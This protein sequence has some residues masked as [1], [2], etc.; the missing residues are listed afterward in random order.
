M[1]LKYINTEGVEVILGAV[2][3]FFITE[4]EGFG[5]VENTLTT[6]KQYALDGEILVSQQ[7]T[8]RELK[9]TGEI[10]ANDIVEM[11]D[12][13]TKLV[14]A[15]NPQLAGTL[16]YSNADKSY[17]IDVVVE[18][19][20]SLDSSAQNLSQEFSIQLKALDPYWIDSTEYNK[21]I[22]LSEVK[23]AFIFPVAV[24]S[25]YVFAHIMTGNITKIS[26]T[27]DVAVGGIF[28]LTMTADVENITI[29]D[30]VTQETF[31]FPH[32][33]D[34]GTILQVNTI[35]GEKQ[36]TKTIDGVTTNA[37]SERGLGSSFLQM[38]KGDNFIQVTAESGTLNILTD[39]KFTPLVMG[40]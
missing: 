13:R 37:I 21:L 36:V 8:T 27:G 5:A 12:L 6:Q 28:T 16:Y 14:S 30:V 24:T 23:G 34:A 3:P 40:V 19:A 17:M 11:Q 32:K 26:N 10:L 1:Q 33:Y 4:K 20:P 31:T 9:L 2:A 29:L 38:A 15:F 18:I 25:E 7:L 22:H 39:F 35:R